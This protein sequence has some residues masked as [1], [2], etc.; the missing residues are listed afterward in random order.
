LEP[1]AAADKALKILRAMQ[2][3][4]PKKR[5]ASLRFVTD[6]RLVMD[7]AWADATEK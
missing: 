3:F 4:T 2:R 5:P 6:D 1:E 7:G